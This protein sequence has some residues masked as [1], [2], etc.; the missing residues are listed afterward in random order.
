MLLFKCGGSTTL[1]QLYDVEVN[2]GLSDI[3]SRELRARPK[4]SDLAGLVLVLLGLAVRV[5]PDLRAATE[6]TND[7]C[8]RSGSESV[9]LTRLVSGLKHPDFVVFRQPSRADPLRGAFRSR[10]AVE[11]SRRGS[12]VGPASGVPP[13]LPRERPGAIRSAR[14][15]LS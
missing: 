6:Y 9:D 10:L 1:L 7:A 11:K 15:L 14:G 8:G 3:L 13:S 2:L 12:P 5:G 4:D